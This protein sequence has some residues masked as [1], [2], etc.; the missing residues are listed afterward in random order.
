MA[1]IFVGVDLAKIAFA[2]HGVNA[3]GQPQLVCSAVALGGLHE[4]IASLPL[5]NTRSAAT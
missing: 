4:L 1:I 5:C 2:V 3:A